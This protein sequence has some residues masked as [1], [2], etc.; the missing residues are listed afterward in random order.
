MTV[1]IMGVAGAGKTTVGTLLAQRL[2]W[3]FLE[4]DALH[5]AANVGKMRRGIPLSDEDRWPWLKAI[6]EEILK[7]EGRGEN[8]VVACSALKASYREFLNS[9]THIAW[10]YLKGSPEVLQARLEQRLG[11]FMKSGMLASQLETLE[12]PED[13]ITV[14]VDRPAAEMVQEICERLKV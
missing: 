14:M 10:V 4:G 2:S 12:E 11:H 6:R 3:R 13:A 5:P 8:L 1:V 9:G 7:S